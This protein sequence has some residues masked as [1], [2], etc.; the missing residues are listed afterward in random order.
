MPERLRCI[1]R[2]QTRLWRMTARCTRVDRRRPTGDTW[3]RRDAPA[4]LSGLQEQRRAPLACPHRSAS[5]GAAA[6]L[7]AKPVQ[8]S[9]GPRKRLPSLARHRP[10]LEWPAARSAGELFRPA[11]RSRSTPR[12]RRA[13]HPG[14][15]ALHAGSPHAVWTAACTGPCR[16]GAGV[17]GAPLPV[18]D[19]YARDLLGCTARLSTKPGEAPPIF[20]GWCR[21]GGVPGAIRTANGAPWATPAFCGRSTRSVWGITLGLRHQRSAPGRPEQHGRHARM[22]RPLNAE[23]TRPP[24]RTQVT[25]Q[26]RCDRFRRAYTHQRPHAALGPC[27]PASLDHA[28]PRRMPAKPAAPEY[29][30]H[31]LGRRVSNA[32]TVRVKRRPL[33][34]RDTLLQEGIAREETDD[35]SWSSSVYDVLLARWD[36]RDCKLSGGLSPR[37]PV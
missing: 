18:A 27:T 37:F 16:P 2:D 35:G 22:H 25:Q 19:A 13:Q 31:S 11:G 14:A 24:A 10:T 12:R 9:G 1:A 30:G 28:A 23:A 6:L 8:P 5:D 3:L 33:V 36:E 32:G 20:A 34:L 4:G 29:P 17:Y 26:A 15:P 7:E 21:A